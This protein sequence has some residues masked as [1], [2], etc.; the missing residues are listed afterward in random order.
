MLIT[1]FES[2]AGKALS[3]ICYNVTHIYIHRTTDYNNL[4]N[5]VHG[6]IIIGDFDTPEKN[7]IELKDNVVPETVD[8]V[9][10]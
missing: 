2:N 9:Q 4:I 1:S 3:E 8:L 6:G 10:D 5:C 7:V